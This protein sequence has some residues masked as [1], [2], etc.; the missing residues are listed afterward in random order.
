M[1]LNA[2]RIQAFKLQWDNL[3]VK[4]YLELQFRMANRR[5]R[6]AGVA[7]FVGY[8]LLGVVF[9]GFSFTLFSRTKFAAYI[10]V[11]FALTLMGNFSETK[12]NEFLK[13]CF[14]DTKSR[15]IR[16]T[17]NSMVAFPFF[18]FLSYKQQLLSG[19][20]LLA[21]SAVLAIVSFRTSINFVIPTPFSQKPFEFSVGFRSTFYVVL[22]S[23]GL[24][25]IAIIVNNFNL[26]AASMILMLGLSAAYYLKPENEYYVWIHSLNV[27]RFLLNKFKIAVAYSSMLLLPIIL[28]LGISFHQNINTLLSLLLLGWLVLACVIVCKYAAFPNELGLKEQ[29]ILGLCVVFMP[30]LIIVIPYF[31]INAK[32]RLSKLLK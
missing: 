20:I 5:F 6:D 31:L 12:R 9:L 3:Q 17:E 7:P 25:T 30:M 13:F 10:Y 21:L 32:R 11:L 1:T 27:N 2:V 29:L 15:I 22:M 14:S 18:I 26:G 8:F 24:S 19:A 4:E 16:F 23:L 28:I